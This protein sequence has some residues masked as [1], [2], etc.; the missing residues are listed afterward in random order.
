[1]AP[2]KLHPRR[3][4][5]STAETRLTEGNDLHSRQSGP[6]CA[7]FTSCV[8]KATSETDAL[9]DGAERIANAKALESDGKPERPEGGGSDPLGPCEQDGS[10][11]ALRR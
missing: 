11:A 1:M 9:S 6:T 5:G 7:I 2:T 10:N 3:E 8:G 4:T